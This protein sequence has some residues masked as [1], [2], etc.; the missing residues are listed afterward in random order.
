VWLVEHCA[1]TARLPFIP[2]HRF[3]Q[4]QQRLSLAFHL[5]DSCASAVTLVHLRY[6]HKYQ[7]ST[8]VRELLRFAS[9]RSHRRRWAC[10]G[11]S[12]I[13]PTLILRSILSATK[14]G[15]RRLGS[16]TPYIQAL[17]HEFHLIIL[18]HFYQWMI[19]SIAQLPPCKQIAQKPFVFGGTSC[20]CEPLKSIQDR[21]PRSALPVLAVSKGHMNAKI[22]INGWAYIVS[23]L[24]SFW[25]LSTFLS[26][27]HPRS[28]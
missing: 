12:I 2:T 8:S 18:P 13:A 15:P 28:R 9:T 16:G 10:S 25:I 7:N 17:I 26:C 6:L 5:S 19:T 23:E 24:I 1:L 11:Y 22:E 3:H 4:H 21:G 27:L 14:V 20:A